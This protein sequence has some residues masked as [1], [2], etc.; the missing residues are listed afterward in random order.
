LPWHMALLLS[1]S[2]TLSSASG[3][4]QTLQNV[5]IIACLIDLLQSIDHF[6]ILV[7][8]PNNFGGAYSRRLVRLSVSPIR[9]RPITLLFEV[10]FR[11]YFTEMTTMLKQSVPRNIC[12]P[13][14]KVKVTAQP[15]SKIVSGQLLCYLKSVFENIS[16]K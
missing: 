3:Y 14:L 9:V 12:V 11:N 5:F 2:L 4:K 15:F 6:H 1:R 8:S 10:G 7:C 16:K 13:T